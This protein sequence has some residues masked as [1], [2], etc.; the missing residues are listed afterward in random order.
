[1]RNLLIFSSWLEHLGRV[2][3][4][5]VYLSVPCKSRILS[6]RFCRELE[7]Y[8]PDEKVPEKLRKIE[9]EQLVEQLSSQL[10]HSLALRE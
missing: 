3:I 7:E 4:S 6:L 9:S 5:S 2:A 10:V 8:Q 1:M